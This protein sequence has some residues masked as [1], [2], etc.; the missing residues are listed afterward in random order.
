MGMPLLAP[1]LNVDIGYVS[2]DSLNA[3]V[4]VCLQSVERW[5]AQLINFAVFP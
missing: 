5:I 3:F 1:A 2:P 4:T